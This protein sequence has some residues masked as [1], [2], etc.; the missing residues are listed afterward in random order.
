[1]TKDKDSP[2]VARAKRVAKKLQ[3]TLVEINDAESLS[4]CQEAAARMMGFGD[5]HDLSRAVAF[6]LVPPDESLS[7]DDL[8]SRRHWQCDAL[9]ESLPILQS[10]GDEILLT[11]VAAL[12]PTT[13]PPPRTR[14]W[15]AT[16]MR[17]HALP[18][19]PLAIDPECID[20]LELLGIVAW[21]PVEA[22]AY[23]RRSAGRAKVLYAEPHRVWCVRNPSDDPKTFWEFIGAKPYIRSHMNLGRA[24]IRAADTGAM[25]WRP[26]LREAEAVFAHLVGLLP[27]R[28]TLDVLNRRMMTRMRLGNPVGARKDAIAQERLAKAHDCLP[29]CWTVWTLAWADLA[30]GK[31]GTVSIAQAIEACPFA[32]PLL[33]DGC[34]EPPGF[35]HDRSGPRAA[36]CYVFEALPSWLDTPGALAALEPFRV[37]ADQ[38]IAAAKRRFAELWGSALS[39]EQRRPIPEEWRA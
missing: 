37:V 35:G 3:R 18:G 16:P 6:A 10:Q 12:R 29:D 20:A 28:M 4:Y 34:D 27:V 26:A 36:G 33:L 15:I 30:E 5:W 2:H 23:H 14:C 9:S 11:I 25:E 32:L 7:P 8:T 19:P 17:P 21:D 38:Q 13:S 39:R 24:L 31:S 22:V 1:M